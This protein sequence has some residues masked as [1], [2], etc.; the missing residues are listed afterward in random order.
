MTILAMRLGRFSLLV[1]RETAPARSL[2][3]RP[4]PGEVAIDLPGVGVTLTDYRRADGR[5]R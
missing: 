2:V 5:V 1:Q 3:S 4:G